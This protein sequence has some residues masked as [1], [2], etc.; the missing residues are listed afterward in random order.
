MSFLGHALARQ[1]VISREE[2]FDFVLGVFC[3]PKGTTYNLR[4]KRRVMKHDKIQLLVRFIGK[5]IIVKI[6]Y[7][8]CL[9]RLSTHQL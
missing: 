6:L 9:A 8:Q 4:Q 2:G 7:W 1:N 5:N 3:R